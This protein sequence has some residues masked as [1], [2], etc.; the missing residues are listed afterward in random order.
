MCVWRYPR[1]APPPPIQ[2]ASC[3]CVLVKARRATKNRAHLNDTSYWAF[4]GIQDSPWR[5]PGLCLSTAYH[6]WLGKAGRSQTLSERLPTESDPVCLCA[7]GNVSP[8]QSVCCIFIYAF[9]Y[10]PPHT[11]WVWL[12]ARK[13]NLPILFCELPARS[14]WISYA[15]CQA[16][17]HLLSAVVFFL[18]F[19]T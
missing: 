3:Q 4:V 10:F 18:Q 1:I 16:F 5:I 7:F 12:K 8:L 11:A 14:Q 2:P 19:S 15:T 9:L 13:E 6:T 17:S